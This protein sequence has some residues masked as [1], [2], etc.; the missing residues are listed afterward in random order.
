[1]QGGERKKS[2]SCAICIGS[3]ENGPLQ[4]AGPTTTSAI[5]RADGD[6]DFAAA[7]FH[8]FEGLRQIV[9]ADLFGDEIMGG[10]IAALD[11]FKRFANEARRVMEG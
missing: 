9:Q 6:F 11:G 5:L 8:A 3:A 7:G 2:E 4:K 10:N 1:M